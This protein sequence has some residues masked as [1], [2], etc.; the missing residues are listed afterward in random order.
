MWKMLRWMTS[1]SFSIVTPTEQCGTYFIAGNVKTEKVRSIRGKMVRRYSRRRNGRTEITTGTSYRNALN[2]ALMRPNVPVD[3]IYLTF[4]PARNHP[5]YYVAD[6]ISDVLAMVP[7]PG[8]TAACSRN[9]SC[10]PTSIVMSRLYRP[11]AYS[12]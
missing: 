5:D 3:A 11:G 2:G 1:G 8:Y 6:L 10:F 4:M 12:S 9:R 7:L